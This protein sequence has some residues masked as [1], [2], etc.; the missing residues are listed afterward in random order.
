MKSAVETWRPDP[1]DQRAGQEAYIR[2]LGGVALLHDPESEL[3]QSIVGSH[4]QLDTYEG[5]NAAVR[6][7]ETVMFHNLQ[8]VVRMAN[9]PDFRTPL[10]SA[11]RRY[12]EALPH[13]HQIVDSTF[14]SQGGRLEVLDTA[15]QLIR[16]MPLV[17]EAM[18][19]HVCHPHREKIRTLRLMDDI[20]V[21]PRFISIVSDRFLG[22]S[23]AS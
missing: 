15:L 19:K 1:E 6:H 12:K 16:P 4:V 11:E 8:D 2:Y 5:M 21:D 10:S 23:N 9:P 17:K 13:I 7:A 22:R 18:Y 3:A 20:M 14:Q